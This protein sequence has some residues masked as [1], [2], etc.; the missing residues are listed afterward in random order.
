MKKL[1]TT[2]LLTLAMALCSHTLSARTWHVS[3]DGSDT[4]DGTKEAPYAT[5][6]KAARLAIARDTILI[7][8]GTYREWVSP[9]N[10][11]LTKYDRITYIAAEGEEVKIKGSEVITGWEKQRGG[12]WSVKIDN[13]IFDNFNPF[14]ILI[15]G[16]WLLT[17]DTYHLGE[18]YI[19]EKALQEVV[20]LDEVAKNEGS[21]Y[22]E[23]QDDYTVVTANFDQN[24]NNA[25]TEYNVRPS[26]FFPKTTGVNFITVKGLNISQAATQWSAPTSEQVGIIGPNWSK[27]WIIEG[28][29][30]SNSKCVGI[31]L[32]KERASGHNLW[33]LYKGKFGYMHHGFTREI[34]AIIK[35]YD[36]GWSIENIGSHYVHDNLIYDCGQAGIVGHLG[37]VNSVIAHNR[38]DNINMASKL[39]GWETAGIKLHAAIDCIVENNYITN[40][41]RGMWFDW[42]AQGAHI[43]NNIIEGSESQDIW[44]EVIHGPTFIY[45]NIFA[46]KVSLSFSGAKGLAFFNNMMLG[47]L[48]MWGS[49]ERYTPYHYPHSTKLKGLFN[50][51]DG[52]VKFYNNIFVGKYAPD[53]GEGDNGG[54]SNYDEYPT[55][56]ESL[57]ADLGFGDS[58]QD[59][60]QFKF[61]IWTGGNIYYKGT[62]PYK[63]EVD[64]EYNYDVAPQISLEERNG[65]LFLTSDIALS[66]LSQ[67]KSYKVD[68]EGLGRAMVSEAVFEN[69]DGTPFT[70]QSD[71]VG[72]SRDPE[73]PG[74]GPLATDL[75][76]PIWTK[77]R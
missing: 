59:F 6:S 38:I 21:W 24:P 72:T 61:P 67:S 68:T 71:M 33:S 65:D 25:I 73:A 13:E 28:C 66:K 76:T 46:S 22:A 35:A 19:N 77:I 8:G 27:G 23:V 30:I 74:A 48:T 56:S 34:E 15:N 5:I 52:D 51:T 18:I 50:N 47:K 17:P 31:C 39:V 14:D 12:V 2:S 55:Y 42:Q 10:G 32:G 11:G 36:L 49:P 60:L 20:T 41:V 40:T 43:R 1:L 9:A 44:V 4:N 70:Y 16:D 63:N 29:E 54:I 45:N 57:S 7:S 69:V 53:N 58:H 62:I 3:A 64:A 26:C 37:V 75:S